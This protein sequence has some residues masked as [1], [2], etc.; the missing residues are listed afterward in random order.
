MFQ[1]KMVRE[2]GRSVMVGI[3]EF[4]FRTTLQVIMPPRRVWQWQQII[5][6]RRQDCHNT[7]CHTPIYPNSKKKLFQVP[8]ISSNKLQAE[9]IL[10][11][12]HDCALGHTKGR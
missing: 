8:G 4:D 9:D 3:V 2:A 6:D 11:A 12:L 1:N 5:G 10:N 7:D